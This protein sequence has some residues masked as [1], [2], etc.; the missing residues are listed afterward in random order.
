MIASASAFTMSSVR[1]FVCR[2]CASAAALYA[3]SSS[4][5]VSRGSCGNLAPQPMK[6]PVPLGGLYGAP[7]KARKRATLLA[8]PVG[9]CASPPPFSSARWLPS[10]SM[11]LSP[12]PLGATNCGATNCRN[13]VARLGAGRSHGGGGVGAGGTEYS[14]RRNGAV[15]TAAARAIAAVGC[16]A[17][18]AVRGLPC[19]PAVAPM[20]RAAVVRGLAAAVAGRALAGRAATAAAGRAAAAAAGRAATPVVALAGAAAAAAGLAAVA[21]AGRAATAAAGRAAAAAAGLAATPAVALAGAAAA[22][23]GLAAV[24]V[25]GRPAVAVTPLATTGRAEAMCL[26]IDLRGVAFK[27]VASLSLPPTLS[28]TGAYF[29]DHNV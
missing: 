18:A 19:R 2:R 22:A 24:A 1:R 5:P 28:T 27:L 7:P 29:H 21:V 4:A 15:A 13:W 17:A 10:W 25:T 11:L 6:P 8:L 3:A 23:A 16:A 9:V 26:E 14:N 12:P 20:G